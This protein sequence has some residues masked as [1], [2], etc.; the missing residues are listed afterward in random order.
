MSKPKALVGILTFVRTSGSKYF[1]E[2]GYFRQLTWEGRKMGIEVFVFGVD[3]V[4]RKTKRIQGFTFDFQAEKWERKWFPYPDMAIDRFRNLRPD[5]IK[6]L[7]AFR[8]D[9]LF[10]FTAHRLANKLK[11]YQ[12]LLKVEKMK[13]WL[14]ETIKYEGIQSLVSML[15]KYQNVFVKP[16]T[17]TGGRSILRVQRHLEGYETKGR[18]KKR[19][20][21]KF[22]ARTLIQLQPVLDNW[23]GDRLYI[24]QQGIPLPQVEG[25]VY[26][27]RILI[28]KTGYGKWDVTGMAARLA[29]K[30]S[31]TSNI[32]GGGEAVLPEK[33]LS[34]SFTSQKVKEILGELERLAYTAAEA[35]EAQYGSMMELGLDVGIDEQGHP[36]I[37]E[38]NSKP[39]RKVFEEMGQKDKSLQAVQRPLQYALYLVGKQGDGSHVLQT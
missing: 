10:P 6:Q 25:R 5:A 35:C 18:D 24:V 11:L 3:E 31:V 33:L 38:I 20:F 28:Q 13:R 4:D 23:V 36:W 39:S 16:A 30:E 32:H 7:I 1:E 19:K 8:K 29:P 2:D 14:P 37:I 27:F 17:G 12:S 9:K 15:K 34:S 22:Q 21:T 26:D